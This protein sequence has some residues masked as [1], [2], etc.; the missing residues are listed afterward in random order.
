MTNLSPNQLKQYENEG[1]V[2]PVDIFSKDRAN[3][4]RNE[5]E[6]IEKKNA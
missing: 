6:F 2:S 1:F 3:E 4:I 5:L